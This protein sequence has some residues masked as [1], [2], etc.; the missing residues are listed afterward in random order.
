MR[1]ARKVKQSMYYALKGEP[2]PIYERDDNGNIIY[3][4]H[5]GEQI[6]KETGETTNGIEEPVCRQ[7]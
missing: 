7:P 1:T 6:P 2:Q 4:I 3:L 5:G